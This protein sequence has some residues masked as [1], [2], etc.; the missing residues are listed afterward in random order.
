ML[1]EF[2]TGS[3]LKSFLRTDARHLRLRAVRHH[4]SSSVICSF[5]CVPGF[6][7][8]HF[9]E[10]AGDGGCAGIEAL[11]FN[12]AFNACLLALFVQFFLST[13]KRKQASKKEE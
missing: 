4:F 6:I 8:Y 12:A 13:Y 7:W 5:L 10:K 9:I 3:A 1:V 11:A 2:W